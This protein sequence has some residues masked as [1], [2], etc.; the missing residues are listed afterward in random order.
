MIKEMISIRP[1]I[2]IIMCS[3]YGFNIDI[4]QADRARI[5]AFVE[6]P[7]GNKVLAAA[8]RKALDE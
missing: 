3:G 4:A 8:V 6:K 1:N 7:V 2:P 5:C